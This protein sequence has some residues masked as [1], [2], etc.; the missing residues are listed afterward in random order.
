[1]F[2]RPPPLWVTA[3][4]R[5]EDTHRQNIDN[6]TT[7][8]HGGGQATTMSPLDEGAVP[9]P[10]FTSNTAGSA[11]AVCMDPIRLEYYRSFGFVVGLAVRTGVAPL[12]LPR[13]APR[14]WMLVA[15]DEISARGGLEGSG[16][17]AHVSQAA[18]K[19]DATKR[20]EVSEG[21]GASSSRLPRADQRSAP[22]GSTAV[23]VVLATLRRLQEGGAAVVTR[24]QQQRLDEILADARFVG[25][26]SN[27]QVVE[28]LPGG[29]A[30]RLEQISIAG[31]VSDS[32]TALYSRQ[33]RRVNSG[34][35][36]PG[37]VR[38]PGCHRR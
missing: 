1:M 5:A 16:T 6:R 30:L 18:C 11:P 19:P 31:G 21:W 9:D 33:S 20:S 32:R 35:R 4:A 17:P 15:E 7:E 27:G 28:L 25:P 8:K 13:L 34:K 14:W 24:Q 36:K 2:A 26:L 37:C 3:A 22:S 29:E 12:P 38:M 23:D 10:T